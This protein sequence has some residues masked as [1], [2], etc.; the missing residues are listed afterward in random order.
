MNN[1]VLQISES[2]AQDIFVYGIVLFFTLTVVIIVHELGHYY[3]ARLCGVRVEKFSVGFGKELLKF[4][5][6]NENSTKW[7][8]CLFPFGGYVKI[9]GDVDP[10]NPVIWDTKQNKVRPLTPTE[11]KYAFYNKSV[12]QRMF[13]VIAG[14]AVN[15]LITFFI[16]VSMFSL[17]G[18]ASRPVFINTIL[19]ESQA[20]QAGV[21]IGDQITS[22]NE[23]PIRRLEDIYNK[24]WFDLPPQPNT[25]H[26]VRDHQNMDITFTA[27]H[28]VYENEKGV[29]M[30]HGQTGMLRLYKVDL[31]EISHINTNPVGSAD[32][33]RTKII[34]NFDQ[35]MT[36]KG[37]FKGKSDHVIHDVF[38]TI[39]PSRH[40]EHFK[41]KNHKD[42]DFVFIESPNEKFYVKLGL[43]EAASQSLFQ[44]KMGL[45][46]SY[47]MIKA[48]FEGKNDD[49]IVSGVAKLS[50]H[51]GE[52]YK[53]GF[54]EFMMAFAIFNYM[55]AIVNLLPIPA[56]DG[57]YLAF[58]GW[59]G[60]TGKPVSQKIQSIT[61]IIG[62]A[63][64][65]GIMVFA[66]IGDIVS[67]AQSW[68]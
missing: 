7:S 12:L 6:Q 62:L 54:Y 67:L 46:N 41:D 32:E 23:D 53:A 61:L 34:E 35:L 38:R 65:W 16:F 51:T 2:L 19:V 13:I 18:Q 28:V 15:L 43:W 29:L 42:Y 24:T 56:L 58:L 45:V 8:F 63:F 22:M 37:I 48:V 11:Q 66:N 50:T 49:P 59:E 33:A 27:R 60:I 44:M 52:A 25:Y 1:D 26:I 14:P 20:D 47:K 10:A 68:N 9:F 5:G 36:F 21:K 64:L 57:G 3:V 55:I 31:T 39:I 17:Y 30:S 4:S 40:N